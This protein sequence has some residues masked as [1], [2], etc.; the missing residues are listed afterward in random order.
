MTKALVVLSGGQDSTTCLFW[1]IQK[2]GVDNVQ[3]I[4]FNYDQRHE[5][6][7]ASAALVAGLSGLPK[8]RHEILRIGAILK[9]TSPLTDMTQ[10]LE[11]YESYEQMDKVIGDRVEKT[12]VPMRNALFLTIAAN[13]AAVL[14]CTAIVTGVC[15]A[16]NANYPDCRQDFITQQE[17]AINEALGNEYEKPGW[18]SIHTP[19]MN[20]SKQQS[21]EFAMVVP[22]AYAA[23]AYSHTAY[24]GSF[25]PKGDDHASVLRAYGFEQAGYPDPLILRAHYLLGHP[26]PN[27]ENYKGT[28]LMLARR[29]IDTDLSLNPFA[30]KFR[31]EDKW[32]F[33]K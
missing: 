17:E 20:M 24:D 33:V 26:L 3:A 11:R 7:I 6:E 32:W 4:T 28:A 9:G 13:R 1:A 22:M 12:F 5:I 27:T 8:K 19:L 30:R 16:D 18:I 25:P 10:D 23:L 21:I 31:K 14:D 29:K 2:F 15:Q